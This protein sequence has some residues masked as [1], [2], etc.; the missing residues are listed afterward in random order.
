[1]KTL[2]LLLFLLIAATAGLA[3]VNLGIYP[4]ATASGTNT[5][6]ATVTPTFTSYVTGQRFSIKF[7][8]A[9]TG[10]ST[11]NINSL[12][13]KSILN[14]LIGAGQIMILQYD[15]VNMQIIGDGGAPLI[16]SSTAPSS[17]AI[18]VDTGNAANQA[19]PMRRFVNGAWTTV[20]DECDWWDTIGGVVSKGKPLAILFSGQSN[21][22]GPADFPSGE[23]TYTGDI[24]VSQ[25][26]SL[27][28]P[29]TDVF[30]VFNNSDATTR[31]NRTWTYPL[32]GGTAQSTD[33]VW[34][35]RGTNAVWLFAKLYAKQFNRSVRVV[36]IGRG[37]QPMAQWEAGKLAWAELT[38]EATA[39][40]IQKFDA[41][42]W[43]HGEAGLN[44]A[45]N[46]S[47]FTTY[48]DS[49][50][51]FIARLKAQ[52][53]ADEKLKVIA[54]SN[55]LNTTNVS[56]HSQ[57][58]LSPNGDVDHEGTV[59]SLDNQDNPYYGWAAAFFAREAQNAGLD[60]YHYTTREHERLGAAIFQTYLSL[61]N[62]KKSDRLFRTFYTNTSNRL[63][64]AVAVLP[65]TNLFEFIWSG[66]N[67]STAEFR[68]S[69]SS[70][71]SI[72]YLPEIR[73]VV[74]GTGANYMSWAIQSSATSPG[75]LEDKIVVNNA[76]V[77]FPKGLIIT[78]TSDGGTSG[79]AS[80][81]IF[82]NFGGTTN[83]TF[84][85]RDAGGY[86]L[87]YKSGSSG[88]PQAIHRFWF[89]SNNVPVFI[90]DENNGIFQHTFN[91]GKV[92]FRNG[93]NKVSREFEIV[94]AFNANLTASA[95]LTQTLITNAGTNLE[96]YI[97]ANSVVEVEVTILGTLDAGTNG[98]VL[99]KSA[100]YY[101]NG[102]NVI[103]LIGQ[104][105][106]SVIRESTAGIAA[107]FTF[108]T[109][110][111]NIEG[112]FTRG[113]AVGTYGISAV[114]EYSVKTF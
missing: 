102:S 46:P 91:N 87:N 25:Y 13:A 53:W 80:G 104:D 62:Y 37:G 43:I 107:S 79:D 112:T 100:T 35:Y 32:G 50:Y 3:Q 34:T 10:A 105:A 12:G 77:T 98:F 103:S 1:M 4:L 29:A 71:G 110:G 73:E 65:N 15:G 6:T 22:G 23:P 40:G 63:T 97:R 108:S 101:K 55:A 39:S 56:G 30:K 96:K 42:I 31:G 9:N 76:G 95:S 27:F 38:S 81:I 48:K 74:K 17:S 88:T 72:G 20:T 2:R 69:F 33:D 52:S 24:T 89:G 8:N 19:Y 114:V 84:I 18:W 47:T 83:D 93:G 82:Q 60:P 67:S 66:G 68:R 111:S 5:Y 85:G 92:A 36:G 70:T 109:T 99:K 11:I 51:D 75:S 45:D 49:F 58:V 14:P 113:A 7:T 57:T 64:S 26:V 44:N 21:A 59:R 16:F 90:L 94:N 54:T 61:P 86:G 28:Q 106:S 78:P 41:F